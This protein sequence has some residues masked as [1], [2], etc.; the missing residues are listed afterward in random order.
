MANHFEKEIFYLNLAYLWSTQS[1]CPH[2]VGTIAT[3]QG[4]VIASGYNG[5]LK[6]F[7]NN[8]DNEITMISSINN[9]ISFALNVGIS[10]KGTTMY[11]THAPNAQEANLLVTI[12]INK[13]VYIKQ[14]DSNIGINILLDS[15]VIVNHGTYF[16]KL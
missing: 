11:T 7:A 4:R 1:K 10:L 13:L 8:C 15:G 9:L 3:T 12:G 2:K 6:G 14:L 16:R 5:T